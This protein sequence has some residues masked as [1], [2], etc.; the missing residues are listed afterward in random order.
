MVSTV[1]KLATSWSATVNT[2]SATLIRE[3]LEAP[4]QKTS[5]L[6]GVAKIVIY[7]R[8]SPR[9]TDVGLFVRPKS[10]KPPL[11]KESPYKL[12]YLH[13]ERSNALSRYKF[14]HCLGRR[15]ALCEAPTA[16]GHSFTPRERQ[17]ARYKGAPLL[18]FSRAQLA[19][20]GPYCAFLHHWGDQARCTFAPLGGS[21]SSNITHTYD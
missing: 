12:N 18:N 2:V 19:L 8:P 3:G 4:S 7:P 13:T 9:L 5:L 10:Q 6:G 1:Q 16:I 21:I 15:P 11:N 14:L 17:H 20:Q